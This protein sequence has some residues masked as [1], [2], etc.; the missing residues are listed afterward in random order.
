MSKQAKDSR[1][2]RKTSEVKDKPGTN[3]QTK[4]RGG[5]GETEKV[6]GAQIKFKKTKINF[7]RAIT[8][9]AKIECYMN[10]RSVQR[11]RKCSWELKI[12]SQ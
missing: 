10:K 11:W 6:Q 12:C 8:N 2:F 7:P 3:K 1:Q 9:E 4:M 5:T